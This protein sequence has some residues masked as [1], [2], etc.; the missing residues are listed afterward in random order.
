M[1]LFLYQAASVRF[2]KLTA[3]IHEV[4]MFLHL[5]AYVCALVLSGMLAIKL[6]KFLKLIPNIRSR[7]FY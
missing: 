2:L 4:D 3:L 1:N 7:I 5:R 6:L